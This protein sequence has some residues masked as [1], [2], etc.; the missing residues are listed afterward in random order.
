MD[1]LFHIVTVNLG[2]LANLA[3]A[4][5]AALANGDF[6]AFANATLIPLV[7]ATATADPTYQGQLLPHKAAAMLV[8]LLSVFLGLLFG[9]RYHSSLEFLGH[10]LKEA[11]EEGL[12]P[13]Q[14]RFITQVRNATF[15]GIGVF[16][17]G[18]FTYLTF[19]LNFGDPVRWP[20]VLACIGHTLMS[21]SLLLCAIADWRARI[22]RPWLRWLVLILG[23]AGVILAP[24]AM[25][26]LDPNLMVAG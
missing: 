14:T 13:A 17:A 12:T 22:V 2:D 15:T 19:G 26:M 10:I 4:P 21:L 16:L 23:L 1:Q 7:D 8:P 24:M 9:L 5:V 25:F 20:F 18:L 3:N 6:A 11:G